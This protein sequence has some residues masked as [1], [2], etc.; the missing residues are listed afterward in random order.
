MRTPRTTSGL[1][2]IF[3]KPVSAG[4]LMTLSLQQKCDCYP[5]C[6]RNARA[7]VGQRNREARCV[8]AG[9]SKQQ[10]TLARALNICQGILSR[11]LSVEQGESLLRDLIICTLP[12]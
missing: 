5:Q 10:N 11:L 7:L 8:E 4:T 6:A 2:R 3:P 12:F 9:G 1:W